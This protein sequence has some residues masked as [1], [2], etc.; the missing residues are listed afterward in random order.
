MMAEV[1]YVFIHHWLYSVH[2]WEGMFVCSFQPCEL[3]SKCC[4]IW[5]PSYRRRLLEIPWPEGGEV[6]QQ[7]GGVQQCL[8][9]CLFVCLLRSRMTPDL[10]GWFI[11]H[12]WYRHH[13]SFTD[14]WYIPYCYSFHSWGQDLCSNSASAAFV[15]S[16]QWVLYC[17]RKESALNWFLRKYFLYIYTS[18]L[19][20]GPP[21]S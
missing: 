15:Q 1:Y 5:V 18:F 4:V 9:V 11:L 19:L 20:R 13:C 14:T 7:L 6:W 3:Q 12:T 8:Q 17:F 16:W 2:L 10:R 21:P